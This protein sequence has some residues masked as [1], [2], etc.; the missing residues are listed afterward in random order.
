[1]PKIW[2]PWNEQCDICGSETEILTDESYDDGYA[3]DSDEVRCVYCGAIGQF[4]V[5]DEGDAYTIFYWEE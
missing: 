3:C 4:S 1:M 5:Y 2:K